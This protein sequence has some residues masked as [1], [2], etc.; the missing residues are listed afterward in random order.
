MGLFS[1]FFGGKRAQSQESSESYNKAFEPISQAFSPM[2]GFAQQGAQGVSDFLGGNTAGF[3][4]YKANTG[5]DYL[6]GR[7]LD[8]V[9]SAQAG[10][11]MF[12]SG[13]TAK[14]LQEF[15][16]G[17][18][19]TYADKYIANQMGLAGLGTSAAQMLGA[20]GTTSKSQGTSKSSEDTGAFGQL[21]AMLAFSDPRLKKSVM[22]LGELK[23]GLGVYKYRYLDN[24]GPFIGVMAD[25]VERIQPEA[26]GP[27][28]DGYKT[29]NYALIEGV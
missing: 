18:T 23:N 14:G 28:I 27:E 25:E 12:N 24:T 26:L 20:T 19:Q 9:N 29:V 5:F 2:L 21:M 4:R 6:L 1:K 15:G 3:D 17:L 13:A 22:K 11:R 16:S 8:N 7:G 10:R